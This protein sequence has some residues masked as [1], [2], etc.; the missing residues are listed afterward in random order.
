MKNLARQEATDWLFEMVL[1]IDLIMSG[2]ICHWHVELMADFTGIFPHSADIQNVNPQWTELTPMIESKNANA[3]QRGTI[4]KLGFSSFVH[5]E[6]F[7]L[8]V[9]SLIVFQIYVYSK[10][11]KAP[12][13]LPSLY[14]NV[15][16]T[17]GIIGGAWD[18]LRQQLINLRLVSLQICS[19][20][21]MSYPERGK[22]VCLPCMDS[23]MAFP[24]V[25]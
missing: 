4:T 22:E 25:S 7:S 19:S 24:M 20:G 3:G 5:F 6:S 2:I 12:S 17:Q 14:H 23:M 18:N 16:L 10:T 11:H 21:L 8:M 1:S 9:C 13:Q 15:A